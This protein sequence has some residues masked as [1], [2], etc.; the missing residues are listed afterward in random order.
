M[1]SNQ[2]TISVKITRSEL[3]DLLLA[4]TEIEY[5]QDQRPNKWSAL[6]KKLYEQLKTYD[7][8]HMEE[9]P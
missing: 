5:A 4:T 1:Y 7:S 6:H 8:K 2:S 9:V 3:I